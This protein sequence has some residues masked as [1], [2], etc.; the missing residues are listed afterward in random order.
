MEL[1][2]TPGRRATIRDVA[3]SSG[4]S[5]ATVSYALNHPERISKAQRLRVLQAVAE[6]GYKPNRLAQGLRRGQ[7]RLIGISVPHLASA[8]F[9]ELVN[10][11]EGAAGRDGYQVLQVLHHHRPAVERLRMAALLDHQVAGLLVVPSETPGA[12]LDLAAAAGVPTVVLDRAQADAR[13][14]QVTFDNRAAMTDVAAHLLDFGHRHI[15][16]AVSHPR[17]VTT[18]QRI[19]TL[20]RLAAGRARV[21]LLRQDPL[22]AMFHDRL[23]EALA[24]PDGATAVIASNTQVGLWTLRGLQAMGVAL[25]GDVSLLVFDHPDW[26]DIVTP[27]ISVV[28]TPAAAMAEA[29][30][31]MLLGRMAGGAGGGETVQLQ[32]SV[33]FAASTAVARVT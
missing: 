22:E 1:T 31:G 14:D 2:L 19:Q 29:A 11:L 9:A 16:F 24:G 12:A 4:V 13:F 5:V 17:L 15:V 10:C 8:Y 20:Q 27:R 25:P 30:W 23:A 32:A 7:S 33:R 3:R 28:E 26:A 21:T 18:R 6:L